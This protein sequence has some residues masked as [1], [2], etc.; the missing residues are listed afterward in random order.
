MARIND[1]AGSRSMNGSCMF[2]GKDTISMYF[3]SLPLTLRGAVSAALRSGGSA[4]THPSGM[5]LSK[6]SWV[7]T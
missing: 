5:Y 1:T 2:S 6:S 7:S 3:F 4:Q